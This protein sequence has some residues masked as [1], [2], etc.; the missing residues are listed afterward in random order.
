MGEKKTKDK[1][2]KTKVFHIFA[3]CS[4][5]ARMAGASVNKTPCGCF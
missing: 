3:A 5:Y 1:S 2:I 4:F